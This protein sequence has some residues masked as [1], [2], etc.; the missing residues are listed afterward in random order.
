MFDSR[1]KSNNKLLISSKESL[2]KKSF[3]LFINNTKYNR[4][5]ISVFLKNIKFP[6]KMKRVRFY[7]IEK[8]MTKSSEKECIKFYG[9]PNKKTILIN[10]ENQ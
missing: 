3:D 10:K 1:K 7:K 5:M 8:C 2:Q 4:Q 9:F 6:Q